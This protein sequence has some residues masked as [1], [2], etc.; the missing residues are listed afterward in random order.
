MAQ[1]NSKTSS[2][3][4]ERLFALL[5][6]REAHLR[7]RIAERREA[8]ETPAS[9]SETPGD[10]ADLAFA[11]TRAELERELIDRFLAEIRQI[12]Q[13]RE[14][15]AARTYGICVECGG[16]IGWPRLRARLTALRC[17]DCEALH[18][19]ALSRTAQGLPGH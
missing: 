9:A 5:E 13:A 18:E 16:A 10:Q 2:L 8:L 6:E 12:E 4:R 1:R 14:R 15:F 3:P 19:K 7:A 17:A 11:R